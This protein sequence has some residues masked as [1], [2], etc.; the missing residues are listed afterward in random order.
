MM[1]R[2]TRRSEAGF[3]TLIEL[4]VVVAIMLFMAYL[5][6][7]GRSPGSR[8]VEKELG[9]ARP[10]GPTSIPGRSIEAARSA[11]CKSNLVQLR[12]ALQMQSMESQKP[13]AS[14]RELHLPPQMLKCPVSG[15]PYQY[16]PSTG[17]VHCVTPGHES[18]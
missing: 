1:S 4:L 14:L 7:G 9:P 18:Y 6:L 16:D 17:Q 11:E 2:I 13:P 8:D 3:V 10:G 12:Q 15:D 5:F